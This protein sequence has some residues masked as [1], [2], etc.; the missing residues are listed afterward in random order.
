MERRVAEFASRRAI[1][2][3]NGI[4]R[5]RSAGCEPGRWDLVLLTALFP[6]PL[7]SSSV[8]LMRPE[9]SGRVRLRSPDADVL[10][11]VSELSLDSDRDLDAAFEGLALGRRL[12]GTGAL[13]GMV[14]EELAPGPGATPNELRRRGREGLTSFF[15]PVGTCPMGDRGTTRPDGRL[16]GVENLYLADASILP[17]IPPVPTNL[18]VLGV[19]ERIAL[20]ARAAL[21]R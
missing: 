20:E 18:T 11:L 1:F 5:A 2:P 10:P 19:A 21:A 15:H 17:E 6:G 13:R 9:W 12:V 16:R 3:I 8:M 14:G 7:L 4:V